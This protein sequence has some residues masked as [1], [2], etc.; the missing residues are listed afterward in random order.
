VIEIQAVRC[1]ARNDNVI[2]L[3]EGQGTEHRVQDAS[4]LV[5]ENDL[6]GVRIA[7]KLSLRL[8]WSTPRECDIVV[9]KQDDPAR[10]RIARARYGS[11]LQMMM[12]K[13]WLIEPFGTGSFH[14]LKLEHAR[15][16]AKMVD[17]AVSA[18]KTRERDDLFVVDPL[19][20][21]PRLM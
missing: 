3:S 19:R 9:A 6:V 20:L 15:G 11:C 16:R 7:E 14:R 12:T 18:C 1:A 4:T 21:E 2:E 10:N 5:D 8:L 13:R 17:E